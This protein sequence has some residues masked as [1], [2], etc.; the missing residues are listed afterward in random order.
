M[1]T[2]QAVSDSG[3][4]DGGFGDWRVEQPVVWE[5]VRQATIDAERAAPFAVLL[6]VGDQELV[7][8]EVVEDGLKEAVTDGDRRAARNSLTVG[9]DPSAVAFGQSSHPC[10]GAWF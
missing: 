2:L 1:A 9:I 5:Q 7:M 3:G 4:H 8:A 6:P 10:A